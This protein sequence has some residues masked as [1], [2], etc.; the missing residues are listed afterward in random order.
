MVHVSLCCVDVAGNN[1]WDADDPRDVGR[2]D[3]QCAMG[4]ARKSNIAIAKNTGFGCVNIG[5][6]N[7]GCKHITTVSPFSGKLRYASFKYNDSTAGKRMTKQTAKTKKKFL[8][9]DGSFLKGSASR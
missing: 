2:G 9:P 7:G 3:F 5:L 8:Q 6:Q 1:P 4:C